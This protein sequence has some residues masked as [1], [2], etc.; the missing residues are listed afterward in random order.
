[1]A[2]LG[3]KARQS[4]SRAHTP[5]HCGL[6][7]QPRRGQPVETRSLI[8]HGAFPSASPALLGSGGGH[9]G[10]AAV[11][12]AIC[13]LPCPPPPRLLENLKEKESLDLGL[14]QVERKSLVSPFHPM[15]LLSLKPRQDQMR[16]KCC[17]VPPQS[18]HPA[19]ALPVSPDADP[20]LSP[21]HLPAH[22]RPPHQH[23]QG[24]LTVRQG[25]SSP[26]SMCFV[27]CLS[28]T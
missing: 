4:D 14:C 9:V 27:P 21:P 19:R 8:P 13:L 20:C 12:G 3:L 2:E 5:H 16:S 23:P 10:V 18:S 7:G 26:D 15:P 11:R 17:P 22:R 1:M 24:M 28:S 6:P 25:Q